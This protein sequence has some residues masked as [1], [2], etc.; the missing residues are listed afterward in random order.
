MSLTWDLGHP[1]VTEPAEELPLGRYKG[2]C[3][4]LQRAVEDI[5]IIAGVR[6]LIAQLGGK[7]YV[8]QK[9][10]NTFHSYPR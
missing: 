6:L 4:I 2:P 7:I 3:L 1:R 5:N 10:K 9:I 8:C